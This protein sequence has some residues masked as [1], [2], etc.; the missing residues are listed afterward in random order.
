MTADQALRQAI[1]RLTAV[2][3]DTPARDAR[4]LMAHA[5][6]IPPERLTLAMSEALPGDGLARFD[7]A[8]AARAARQPVSQI[9]GWREFFGRRFRVTPDVLDP[10][11]DTETLIDAALEMPFDRVLDLGTGS[12]CILLTLLLE[13]NG[14]T[15]VG[16][17]I[18]ERAIDVAGE[19]RAALGLESRAY[20]DTSDW[21]EDVSG[22]F[23]LITSN[24]PYIA[25]GEM[26]GLAPEVRDYEPRIALTPGGDGLDAYRAIAKHAAR[27][28]TPAGHLMLEI[29]ATQARAVSDIFT[30]AGLEVAPP[31]KDLNGHDRVITARLR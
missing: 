20:F 18:S 9:T 10:R 5:L 19:N 2:G 16:T 21:L 22:R 8:I 11:P 14:A 30:A 1:A 4:R 13:R 26:P 23:D 6:R 15:G 28:L 17:D 31:H 29:G 7:A 25:E 3:V 24:P 27:H 12:G